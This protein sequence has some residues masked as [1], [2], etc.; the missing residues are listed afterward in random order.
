[1]RGGRSRLSGNCS[2]KPFIF[3]KSTFRSS[4]WFITSR[5]GRVVMLKAGCSLPRIAASRKL[6]GRFSGIVLAAG[7]RIDNPPQIANLP[8]IVAS[9]KRS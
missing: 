8:H 2:D 7:R 9:R 5:P 4:C 3:S 6:F 1:M